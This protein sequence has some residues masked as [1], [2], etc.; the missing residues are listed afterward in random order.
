MT[1]LSDLLPA[2][3]ASKQLN[4]TADG[5]IASGQTVAL[6]TAG[7]VKAVGLI[8]ESVGT[9]ANYQTN[10]LSEYAQVVADPDTGKT[11]IAYT[12]S[13]DS[14]KGKVVIATPTASG[15][16][17]YGTPVEFSSTASYI[18][19]SYD[20]GQDKVLLTYRGGS[21]HCKARVGTVSGTSISFGTELTVEND[22]C[23]HTAVAYSPDSA[24]H[25]VV[26]DF[27]SDRGKAR[28]LTVSGT[29]VSKGSD[30]QFETGQVAQC[31]IAYDESADAFVAS[32]QDKGNSNYGTAIVATVSGT[33]PS[34][35]TAVV[36]E[37]ANQGSTAVAYDSSA[38][39]VVIT[40][41]DIGNSSYP[42]A[43]V[44]T[45]SGT[46]IS[47]GSS[48]VIASV[49]CEMLAKNVAYSST[50]NKT[51][52][53]YR[54]KDNENGMYA[55]GTVSGTSISFATP[56][57]FNSGKTTDNAIGFDTTLGKFIIAYSDY[58]GSA[59]NT[60]YG[61]AVTLQLPSTNS[62]SFFGIADAAISDAASGKITMKGGVATNSQLLPLAYTGSVG[63]EVVFEAGRADHSEPIFDSSNNKVVIV[64]ADDDDSAHGKAI[65]GTVSGSSIS[66]GTAVTFN[67][68]T[69]TRISGT[70]DSN[71][72]KIV[73]NYVDSD[74]NKLKSRVG[75][76]SG[77]S[78][79]FGTEVIVSGTVTTGATTSTIFDS[80][81]NKVVLFYRDDS[82]SDYG[83][84]AVGTVSGTDISYGTPV[85]FESANIELF[86]HSATFDTS[87]NKT[88][89]VYRDIGNLSYGT[90][91]VGT[92][93]GTSI[94]FGT[95]NTYNSFTTE[96]A[97]CTFDSTNNKV[98]V[99][100][101]NNVNPKDIES[102]V[103]TVSGTSISFGSATS[104]VNVGTSYVTDIS[105][106]FDPDNS[107]IVTVYMDASNSSYGTYAIGA[108]SGDAISFET[109][110]VFAAATTEDTNLVYDTNADK[111]VI[112]FK[113]AANSNYGTSV[114]L[115][116]T[117]A[118]PNLVPNTTYYVQDDGTISTTSSSVTAG[119]ALSTNS[120]NLDYSS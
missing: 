29:D 102:R 110:V 50:N 117:G 41:R 90:A 35:G 107:R 16:I 1:N 62:G 63:S 75:T 111:F 93:S 101:R 112:S 43:I 58:R 4:F 104:I 85:V 49:E 66:Y 87:N 64:Y 91:I 32:Y 45:V 8:A 20:T 40:F 25:L 27:N 38:Q 78:I 57:V 31:G 106:Q 54:D 99:V 72:N 79:S 14:N 74:G 52:I 53:V 51:V 119:K 118:Y 70:F 97:V 108:V 59:S 9:E 95:A 61:T 89:V 116:I 10:G 109:P 67:A 22:T 98:V 113:D 71:S 60:P 69:T 36:Y 44:G 65:V 56:V 76:V 47:F 80:N 37:S 94:S 13:G 46:S 82:N 86:Q 73:V 48:V 92:V 96:D 83:T 34:F 115:T 18:G 28:V 84:A 77:T 21:N 68:A 105:V 17:S 39:K 7:T 3:A 15:T 6:Q 103:G 120:I 24:N 5:A 33:T 114:V 26:Y 23:A 100:Y 11:V 81:S 42:T 2:G 19:M 88:V 55:V 30:V 12:D